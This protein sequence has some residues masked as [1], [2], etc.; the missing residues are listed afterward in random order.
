MDKFNNPYGPGGNRSSNFSYDGG[1]ND[2]KPWNSG[3]Q[4]YNNKNMDRRGNSGRNFNSHENYGGRGNFN[5]G[6]QFPNRKI[7]RNQ[8]N[9]ES[10]NK[11]YYQ[12]NSSRDNY[13]NQSRYSRGKP[14]SYSHSRRDGPPNY[15]E[16][17]FKGGNRSFKKKQYFDRDDDGSYDSNYNNNGDYLGDYGSSYGSQGAQNSSGPPNQKYGS[18]NQSR[19][20]TSEN[21]KSA[22][23][24]IA[25]PPPTEPIQGR[26][27]LV[28]I[29]PPN[30]EMFNLIS[31]KMHEFG[32]VSSEFNL[33]DVRGICFFNY[34][35]LRS[36][37]NS[38]EGMQGFSIDGYYINV[39]YSLPKSNI[40][41]QLPNTV[42][43]QGT[44]LAVLE[45]SYGESIEAS[46][47][48]IFKQFGETRSTYTLEGRQNTR[49]VEYFDL[50][51]A[52]AAYN[53][54]HGTSVNGKG[55]LHV[56]YL[57]DGSL[58]GWPPI[59]I[60]NYKK[61]D[62]SSNF[63]SQKNTF[64]SNS[65]ASESH[66]YSPTSPAYNQGSSSYSQN[67]SGYN[68]NSYNNNEN[69]QYY[70]SDRK[71]FGNTSKRDV[72][73]NGEDD[74]YGRQRFKKSKWSSDRSRDNSFNQ[75]FNSRG[76]F[77]N[78]DAT[79]KFS[80]NSNN[81]Y[82][83][84]SQNYQ[85]INPN[86]YSKNS[87]ELDAETK[88]PPAENLSTGGITALSTLNA[89]SAITAIAN[90]QN[91]S[92]TS[93]PG[94]F[95][96]SPTYPSTFQS[97]QTDSQ[98]PSTSNKE[99]SEGV[100]NLQL[101]SA[102]IAQQQQKNTISPTILPASDTNEHLKSQPQ[103]SQAASNPASPEVQKSIADSGSEMKADLSTE[104]IEN[105]PSES[106]NNE[107]TESLLNS[108]LSE[109][110]NSEPESEISKVVVAEIN[111][112]TE[113][114]PSINTD[115][116]KKD[117]EIEEI[118]AGTVPLEHGDFHVDVETNES[119]NV[120]QND[121]NEQNEKNVDE[122][123]NIDGEKTR[124]SNDSFSEETVVAQSDIGDASFSEPIHNHASDETTTEEK[125]DSGDAQL[126]PKDDLAKPNPNIAELLDVLSQV[127]SQEG[128][129]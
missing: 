86:Y 47:E 87:T 18:H 118:L 103:P 17:R 115:G 80:P 49:V 95:S 40:H 69:Y 90:S 97:E 111:T 105:L 8:G 41:T 28:Q 67:N 91:K 71:K 39:R 104:A 22:L 93:V 37:R 31:E 101:I 36:A 114:E 127:K 45:S 68:P 30:N 35:D 110:L 96:N 109:N 89:I 94:N 75:S 117:F 62:T 43:F 128:S 27:I 126:E 58:G 16:D 53:T 107:S 76:S 50:R 5:R 60:E 21:R 72:N 2:R 24:I 83:S 100:T 79:Q 19:Y 20:G 56:I 61:G 65:Y 122:A 34:Q 125:K 12:S 13:S 113:N 4:G 112:A 82:N 63:A 73:D 116:E 42:K 92:A 57:W 84:Q 23:G 52:E 44:I 81:A 98:N 46:D 3:R 78:P 26:S 119:A 85:Y 102:L 88:T 129:S 29:S 10:E 9:N 59:P 108:L 25:P 32:D 51:A 77:E 55:K 1:N 120:L 64:N 123:I 48:D 7:V 106:V 11:P 121:V 99:V 74:E 6:P 66:G 124:A 70:Q 14:Q 33:I 15:R 38:W 54:L